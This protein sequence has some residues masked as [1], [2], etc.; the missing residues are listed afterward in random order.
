MSANLRILDTISPELD[1]DDRYPE[2]DTY[3]SASLTTGLPSPTS[4]GTKVAKCEYYRRSLEPLVELEAR[5]TRLLSSPNEDEPIRLGPTP[6]SWKSGYYS[7]LGNGRPTPTLSIPPPSAKSTSLPA[8][9]E[10][11]S[12]S[13]SPFAGS[14][15]STSK[16][17]EVAVH[18]TTNWKK[19]FS[20]GGKTKSPKSENSGEI[21]GWWEDPDDPAHALNAL[22]QSM[23]DLWR[24]RQVRR[25]LKEKQVRLEESSGLYVLSC[26]LLCCNTDETPQLSG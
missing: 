4:S 5:L 15:F 21:A 16:D 11:T 8:S 17:K 23:V 13:S 20:L 3:N 24:D 18:T 6:E 7:S 2:D 14:N 12:T 9:P 19:A 25:T 10:T 1:T 26:H 22:A